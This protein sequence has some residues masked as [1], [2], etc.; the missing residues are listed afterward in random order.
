VGGGEETVNTTHLVIPAGFH[1]SQPALHA[2]NRVSEKQG[3]SCNYF[4]TGEMNKAVFSIG[5]D[6]LSSYPPLP[7]FEHLLLP[8]YLLLSSGLLLLG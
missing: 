1:T 2:I 3:F 6:T 7:W 5:G 8:L 4:L